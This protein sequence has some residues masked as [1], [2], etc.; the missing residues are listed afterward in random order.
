MHSVGFW[1]DWIS[2]MRLRHLSVCYIDR[3][4]VTLSG[5]YVSLALDEKPQAWETLGGSFEVNGRQILAA[6]AG[7]DA[8]LA[9]M[10]QIAVGK[11][12]WQ[13]H[14][15]IVVNRSRTR[16]VAT[17]KL[18]MLKLYCGDNKTI[19]NIMGTIALSF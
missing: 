2:I 7:V 17:L 5:V 6:R 8:V 19:S 1:F 15:L 14:V 9:H 4:K 16:I 18:D 13:S 11:D 10:Q 12:P 3:H